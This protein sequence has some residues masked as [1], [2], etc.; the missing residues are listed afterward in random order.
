M[1]TDYQIP[2][3]FLFNPLKQH[4]GF[5]REFIHLRTEDGSNDE[6]KNLIKKLKHLGSSVMDVYTGSLPVEKICKEIEEILKQKDILRRESFSLWSGIKINNFRIISLSDGSQW[7]LKYHDNNLK[8]VHLF[9]ARTSQHTFRVKANTLKSALLYYIIIG[10][11]FITGSDLNK[12]RLLLGLS[13]IRDTVDTEAITE[14]IE[15]LRD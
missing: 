9:P 14:M 10:K 5:I 2:E 1:N 3:P 4:L 7:T 12:V 13:P 15:I 6:I 11:D 8:F